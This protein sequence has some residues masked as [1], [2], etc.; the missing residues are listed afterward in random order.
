MNHGTM[1]GMFWG[2]LV[3]AIPPV[4]LGIGI[5]IHIYRQ[6]RAARRAEEEQAAAE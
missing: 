6:Q 1:Q 5:A 2:G 4:V 3:M